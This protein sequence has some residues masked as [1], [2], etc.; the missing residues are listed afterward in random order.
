MHEYDIYLPS[1]RRDGAAITRAELDAIKR[2]LTEAFGGYT[3]LKSR[4]EGAWRV[5]GVT[6]R[7]EITILRIL[8]DGRG[9]FDM[10]AFR[11]ALE[12]RLDQESVLIVSRVVQIV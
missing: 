11:Q 3:H 5:A 8:D 2:E 4:S 12:R 10:Q 1:Q 6:F 9:S 7:D